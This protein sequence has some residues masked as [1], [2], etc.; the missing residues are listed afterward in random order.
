MVPAAAPTFSTTMVWPR[1]SPIASACSRALASTPPPAAN[2]TISV[3]GRVGQSCAGAV[4]GKAARAATAATVIRSV[5]IDNSISI[6]IDAARFD[7]L[8]PA[9]K[10]RF[11]ELRQEFRRPP[12]LRRHHD[13]DCLEAIDHGGR[14]DGV[15]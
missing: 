11:H 2:G 1:I 10:L 3:I 7:R 5:V 14:V 4:A 8:D 9:G 13:A 15:A 12:I 6:E